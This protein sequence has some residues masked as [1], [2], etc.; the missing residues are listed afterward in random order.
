MNFSLCFTSIRE[1]LIYSV[2]ELWL[3]RAADT[4][5]VE[6]VIAVDS[7]AEACCAEALRT[8]AAFPNRVKVVYQPDRPGTC[9]KGWNAA[10]AKATGDVLIAIADDFEPPSRW[11]EKLAAVAPDGWHL[12]DHVVKVF[13]GYNPDLCTLAILTKTRYDHFGYIFYPGYLSLFSD[14]EF[15]NLASQGD[16]VLISA[17]NL[18][19]EHHHPDCG[20]RERDDHDLEHASS[21]RWKLGELLYEYRKEHGFPID[22][23]PKAEL[24]KVLQFTQAYDK[25][26]AYIQAVKDD[27]CLFDVCF[28]LAEEGIRSF[29]FFIPDHYWSGESVKQDEVAEVKAIAA[30]LQQFGLRTECHYMPVNFKAADTRIGVETEFRN[31]SLD[32]IWAAGFEHAFIV[33]GDELWSYGFLA[34]ITPYLDQVQALQCPMVPVIGLPG[35]PVEGATDSAVV[36]IKKGNKFSV[37]RTP[38]QPATMFN[39]RG[40]MHFTATRKT[41]AE[42]VAKMKASGHYDD[43]DY[44]FDGWIQRKLPNI[45]PGMTDAHMYKPYQIWPLVRA[46]EKEEISHVPPSIRPFLGLPCNLAKKESK[47]SLVD[48][49]KLLAHGLA[50]SSHPLRVG[51]FVGGRR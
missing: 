25:Y 10:A 48:R 41:M 36:Y 33:D 4:S 37:C 27:F 26:A 15:T 28:R 16:G 46:W 35:Y 39:V 11:D 30:K 17:M 34:S 38:V 12:G 19:F 24:N 5:R 9:V 51:V 8:A 3:K 40:V 7:W 45:R 18:R 29:F 14:T 23:G 43:P 22:L 47:I 2:T 13:D 6:V 20:R 49:A 32:I 1:S 31:R 21:S 44:D 42:I 50:L